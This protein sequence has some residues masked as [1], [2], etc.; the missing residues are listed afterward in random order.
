MLR[1]AFA[2]CGRNYKCTE[3]K[4]TAFKSDDVEARK[5]HFRCTRIYAVLAGVH[6]PYASAKSWRVNCELVKAAKFENP[7]VQSK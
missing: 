5:A 3:S 7:F 4:T 2:I 1:A 6:I